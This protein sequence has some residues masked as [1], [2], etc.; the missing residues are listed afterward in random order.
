MM[1]VEV[2]RR[3]PVVRSNERLCWVMLGGGICRMES[4]IWNCETVARCPAARFQMV[5]GVEKWLR[6]AAEWCRTVDGMGCWVVSCGT[7]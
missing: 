2:V 1:P 6:V 7:A 5:R 3:S 4:L